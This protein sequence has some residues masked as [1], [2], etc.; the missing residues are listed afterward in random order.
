[1]SALPPRAKAAVLGTELEQSGTDEA[2]KPLLPRA[3]ADFFVR[4]AHELRHYLR[5]RRGAQD[6]DDLVQDAFLRLLES[7]RA[8]EIINP[9]AWLYRVSA[10]LAADAGDHLRVR[11]AVHV[12]GIEPD[13]LVADQA[14]LLH[15]LHA[16]RQVQ[17]LWTALQ[18]L[19]EACRHAFLLNRFDGLSQREIAQRLGLSEKTVER[20]V[21]RALAACQAA[22]LEPAASGA[23][24]G[25]AV[26]AAPGATPAT[27]PVIPSAATAPAAGADTPCPG[28]RP[29]RNRR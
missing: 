26:G 2:A 27:S 10:N 13:S 21:L 22:C 1:M 6:A 16:R 19:P 4:H 25:A 11:A 5:T 18:G 17:H 14:D 23:A 8:Q 28:G 24:P 15:A 29:P 12:D 9:R 3:I 7:G 20:H